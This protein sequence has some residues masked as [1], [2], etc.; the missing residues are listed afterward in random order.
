MN[1]PLKNLMNEEYCRDISN[2][3]RSALNTMKKNG[4]YI[5]GNAPYGYIKDPEDKHHLVLI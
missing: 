1:L 5:S 2:K 3:I 4:Q